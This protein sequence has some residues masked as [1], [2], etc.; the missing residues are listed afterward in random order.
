[1]DECLNSLFNQL[2]EMNI[3][4]ILFLVEVEGGSWSHAYIML[5]QGFA[6]RCMSMKITVSLLCAKARE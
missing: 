4:K 6:E 3:C 5:L 1:M 2:Q